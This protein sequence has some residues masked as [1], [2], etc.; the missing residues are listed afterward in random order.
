MEQFCKHYSN[1]IKNIYLCSIDQVK[2]IANNSCHFQYYFDT[3][4]VLLIYILMY[5]KFN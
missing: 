1:K 4:R 3:V 5:I 2:H